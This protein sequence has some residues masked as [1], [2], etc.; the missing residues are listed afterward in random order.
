[1][2][3]RHWQIVYPNRNLLSSESHQL[4]TSVRVMADQV[5]ER[6]S[7][8]SFHGYERAIPIVATISEDTFRLE[9]IADRLPGTYFSMFV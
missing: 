3:S 2:D 6:A 9:R 5:T 8:M 7:A 4:L 1:M